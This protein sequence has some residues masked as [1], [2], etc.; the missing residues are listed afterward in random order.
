[1]QS[2]CTRPVCQCTVVRPC[3]QCGRDF[4]GRQYHHM[5]LPP[6]RF[7]SMRCVGVARESE[8]PAETVARFWAKVDRTGDCWPWTAGRSSDGYGRFSIRHRTLNAHRVVWEWMNGPIPDGMCVRHRCDNPPCVRP[9]HLMLG[10]TDDNMKDK[11]ARG[12]QPRGKTHYAHLHPET[13]RGERNPAAKIDASIVAEI[14]ARY[15]AGGISQSGLARAYGLSQPH[16]SRI[17]RGE[18]W[19]VT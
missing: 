12:R 9:D 1:M 4:A 8:T 6:T 15:T 17:V 11:V 19:R 3:E 13:R 18:N 16:V 2:Q 5:G 14:I 10:T 7:C